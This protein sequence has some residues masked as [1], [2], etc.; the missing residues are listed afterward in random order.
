MKIKHFWDTLVYLHRKYIC[1]VLNNNH[2]CIPMYI[3]NI[4]KVSLKNPMGH[5]GICE[6]ENVEQYEILICNQRV[7][8]R[9]I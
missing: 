2:H 8:T 6:N 4:F 7:G 5:A 3:W 9:L 1:D